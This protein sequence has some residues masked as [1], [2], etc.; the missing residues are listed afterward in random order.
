MITKINRMKTNKIKVRGQNLLIT[1]FFIV[2]LASCSNEVNFGE[3]YKKIV[4]IVNSNHLF[5]VG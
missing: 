5:Y 1:F 2:V 3:Q 4:Y